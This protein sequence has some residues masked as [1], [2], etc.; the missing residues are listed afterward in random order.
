ME[1]ERDH[2][3]RGNG[4]KTLVIISFTREGGYLSKNLMAALTEK[5]Y[6]CE[7]YAPLRFAQ[8][9]DIKPLEKDKKGFIGARWGQCSFVFI[10]AVGIAIR[11]IA[12]WVSDKFHDSAVL[13][14]DE[15]G[16]YIIPLLSGHV[17]GGVELAKEIARCSGAVPV[18]TT[19]TDIRHKFAVDVFAKE[20][21][22]HI[23]SK[24]LAKDISAAILE[25]RRVGLY[26]ALP[27]QGKLP[28]EL[29]LC[30]TVKEL[31]DWPLGIAV[32]KE[33][34]DA[35]NI[36]CLTPQKLVVGV[37]CRRGTDRAELEEK[38]TKVLSELEASRFQVRAF[39]SID[40]KKDEIGIM[41]LA[42]S[43]GVPFI[44]YCAEELRGVGPVSSGSP[45]VE[46]ITGVDNVCERA[47][48]KCSQTGKLRLPKTSLCGVT[49]SIFQEEHSDIK[50]KTAF[51]K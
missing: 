5:G 30:D 22:L 12:P 37:G 34:I 21:R 13:S 31:C 32:T 19:A 7:N 3:A 49:F 41:E 23:G 48:R 11:Y 42:R 4:D 26:S 35:P 44:T 40:L 33:R 46:R 15:K 45:F 14:M 38:L 43:Y 20:N 9:L 47:A 51:S 36:L 6:E 1:S 18:I 27:V 50:F 17:G 28:G 2:K 39:A 16:E 25:G 29:C 24:R 10:G 8:E